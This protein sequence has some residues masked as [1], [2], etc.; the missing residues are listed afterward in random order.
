[1]V[2]TQCFFSANVYY[3]TKVKNSSNSVLII[4]ATH[5]DTNNTIFTIDIRNSLNTK[6]QGKKC[7]LV[8]KMKT[9]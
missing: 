4:M 3:I 2:N 6:Y 7:L 5:N 8:A 1:M 9:G